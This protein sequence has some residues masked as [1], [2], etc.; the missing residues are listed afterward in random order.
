M[1]SVYSGLLHGLSVIR[2][3]VVGVCVCVCGGGD[4]P[5]ERWKRL[6]MGQEEEVQSRINGFLS[7]VGMFWN[8]L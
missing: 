3:P 8:I 4:E 2:V 1:V 7:L 5:L 6:G